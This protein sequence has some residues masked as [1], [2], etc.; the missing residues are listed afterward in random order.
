MVLKDRYEKEFPAVCV[1]H[2]W[3][4]GNTGKKIPAI[5]SSTTV[6]PYGLPE[7]SKAGGCTLG[8]QSLRISLTMENAEET[9][10]ILD[11][12]KGGILS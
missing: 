3:K 7:G 8:L 1:C 2:P 4:T 11:E 9:E 6:S 5:I 10:K 12:F